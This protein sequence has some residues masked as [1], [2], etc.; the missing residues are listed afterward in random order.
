MKIGFLIPGGFNGVGHELA[1]ANPDIDSVVVTELAALRPHLASIDALICNTS[2]YTT[3]LAGLLSAEAGR[4][5]WLQVMSSGV[6]AVLRAGVPQGVV[7][8]GAS[9]VHATAVADHAVALL[10]ALA[11]GIPAVLAAQAA[12]VWQQQPMYN[13]VWALDG[14]RLLVLGWG[15]IGRGVAKRLAAADADVTAF[16][17]AGGESGLDGVGLVPL[18]QLDAHLPEADALLLCLPGAAALDGLIGRAALAALP[19]RAL[20]VNVGRGNAVDLDALA[21]ALAAGRIAGAGLDVFAPEPLPAGHRLWTTPNVIVSPHLAGRGGRSYHHH[22]L[23]IGDNITRFR[24]GTPLRN[25]FDSR[26][27]G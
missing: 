15:P 23:L 2:S 9:G 20:V 21:D 22:R 6:D 26:S 7:L 16:N 1:A 10:L 25:V 18:A 19:S 17:R 27:G 13:S 11:R 14:R 4:L 24:A 12:G 8:T 5:R 3:E